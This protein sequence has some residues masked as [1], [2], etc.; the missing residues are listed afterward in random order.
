MPASLDAAT[1]WERLR[2]GRKGAMDGPGR[3]KPRAGGPKQDAEVWK[4]I[5]I[6]ARKE[7]GCHLRKVSAGDLDRLQLQ[8]KK[9]TKLKAKTV[10]SILAAVCIPIR[11]AFRVGRISRHKGILSRRN[12]PYRQ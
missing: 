7:A 12:I 6:A 3:A 5:P 1:K 10:N 4:P 9:E 11:E 8:I 2:A